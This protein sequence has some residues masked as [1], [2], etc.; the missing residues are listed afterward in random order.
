MLFEKIDINDK[1]ENE[2]RSCIIIFNFKGKEL[3]AIRNYGK[4]LGIKDQVVACYKNGESILKDIIENN[5]LINDIDGAKEKV[6]IFNNIAPAKINI[7]IENLKKMRINNTLMAVVTDT[8]KN[9]SLNKLIFNLIEER[10]SINEGKTL[11]HS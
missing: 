4:I 10:K 7:F 6:V 2:G 1:T 3:T 9:W 8:S 11:K 5:I